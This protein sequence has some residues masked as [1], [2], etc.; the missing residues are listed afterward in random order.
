[1][2]LETEFMFLLSFG[3][4]HKVFSNILLSFVQQM[5]RKKSWMAF[6]MSLA[7]DMATF[8]RWLYNLLKLSMPISAF[9]SE[10]LLKKNKKV[11]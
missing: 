10:H 6:R 9:L 8:Y 1:M 3:D 2:Y 11:V 5:F 7:M 4:R